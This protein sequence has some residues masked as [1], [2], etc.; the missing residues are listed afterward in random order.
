MKIKEA[1]LLLGVASLAVVLT[2][3][4]F[5]DV[6][7]RRPSVAERTQSREWEIFI[8]S[9]EALYEASIS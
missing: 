6:R 4:R 9:S 1:A 3:G 2:A 5:P 8:A 7:G